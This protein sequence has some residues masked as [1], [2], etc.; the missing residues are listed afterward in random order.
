MKRLVIAIFATVSA[1]FII[2]LL[3]NFLPKERIVVRGQI[4]SIKEGGGENDIIIKLKDDPKTYYIN[5]GLQYGL[6]LDT[7][8]YYF[9]GKEAALHFN[10]TL[11]LSS[12]FPVSGISAGEKWVHKAKG[13]LWEIL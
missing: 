10:K 4:V 5:R 12:P 2:V 1:T 9:L 13:G 3:L 7:L 6:N 8:L 11:F